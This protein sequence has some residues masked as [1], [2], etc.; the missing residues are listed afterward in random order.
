MNEF[1]RFDECNVI[2]DLRIVTL[3]TKQEWYG[4]FFDKPRA[5]LYIGGQ[6]VQFD[7]FGWDGTSWLYFCKEN[8]QV[9]L[10]IYNDL[11]EWRSSQNGW[12]PVELDENGCR[13][14]RL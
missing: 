9:S 12:A 6:K 2:D 5:R 10:E 14:E 13:V 8:P 11:K 3:A 4:Q 7:Y 1:I